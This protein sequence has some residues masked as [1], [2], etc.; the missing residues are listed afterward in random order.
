MKNAPYPTLLTPGPVPIPD[1]VQEALS[2]PTIH[3]RTPEFREL[4]GEVQQGLQYFFQTTG[5]TGVFFG[6]GSYGVEMSMQ[7]LF[8]Q[9][10][11]V[12]VLNF[13]K[14][15]ERWVQFGSHIGLEV[16]EVKAEWGKSPS[17][18]QVVEAATAHQDL[19]GVIFTH[20]ETST[21]ALIDLEEMAFSLRRSHPDCL[22]VVDAITSAGA[23]PYYH[24]AWDLDLSLG[25]SQKA[26]MNPAGVVAFAI[27][28]RAMDRLSPTFSGDY[29]NLY[30]YADQAR[31]QNFPFTAPTQLMYGL[32][33]ALL[34][35]MA[36]GYP[37]IWNHTHQMAT[38]FR[39]ALVE[40]GAGI[41]PEVP[42]PTLTAFTVPGKETT[43]IQQQLVA[44]MGIFL[45]GGQGHLKGKIL[46]ASHLAEG[47]Q[48]AIDQLIHALNQGQIM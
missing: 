3:H 44:S 2:L 9:G 26:L 21:G 16:I 20:S 31:E 33:A 5:Q 18:Q 10:E 15:S 28:S 40:R 43:D 47:N 22:L 30:N 34:H 41:F 36:T 19:K 42:S 8:H 23:M 4:Y 7:S 45:A 11:K 24:D 17:V 13:G 35:I 48:S 29:A 14:F 32:K 12:M 27:S 1:F 37:K 39:S 38:A 6:S 25:S 46:R